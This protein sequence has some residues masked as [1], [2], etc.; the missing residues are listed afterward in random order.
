MQKESVF[1]RIFRASDTR[2]ARQLTRTF[3]ISLARTPQRYEQFARNNAAHKDIERFEAVDGTR[4]SLEELEQD[5]IVAGPLPLSKGA[6]GLAASHR[7]LWRYAVDCAVPVTVCE[8]D[9]FLHDQFS[10]QSERLLLELGENWD[11]VYWGWNFDALLLGD[12]PALTTCVM[13]FDQQA[14]RA[15]KHEYLRRPVHPSMMR[16][17]AAFGTM[18]YSIS[19]AGA[20]K[21]LDLCFPLKQLTVEIPELKFKVG[22][23]GL[24]A[25]MSH[26]FR[27][28]SSWACFPPLALADNEHA[29]STVQAPAPSP[30][31]KREA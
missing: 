6:L 13:R 2:A 10:P 29:T 31:D 22:N 26:R 20:S 3:V 7:Q 25:A 21:F 8:D 30:L 1:G 9:A 23:V 5:G 24:D 19:P 16:M 15:N 12:I 17:K 14:M 27:E 18:C 28:T 11:L 4:L